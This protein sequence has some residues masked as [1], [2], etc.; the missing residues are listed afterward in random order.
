MYVSKAVIPIL[1]QQGSGHILQISSVGGR[2]GSPGLAAYQ[3]AKYAVGGFSGILG[4]EVAPF[5]VKVTV[6]EPGRMATDWAGSSMK[7][8]PVSE[9]YQ[10]TVG[11]FAEFLRSQSDAGPS[12]PVKVA[13]L[14]LKLIDIET[15]P[16][17]L[18]V[19]T[20]AYQ[21]ATAA[22]RALLASDEKWEELSKS[23]V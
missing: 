12:K 23:A 22:G 2:L 5:G 13:D 1:R 8:P 18:L 6:L 9:P 21:Y 16:A 14:I 10:Q 17:K 20:D 15:P 4:Q 11:A 3:S 19:G 7:I